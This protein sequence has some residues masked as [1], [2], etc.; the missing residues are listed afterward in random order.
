MQIKIE[1]CTLTSTAKRV[2][3]ENRFGNSAGLSK[4]QLSKSLLM[5]THKISLFAQWINISKF[6]AGILA[7]FFS[8]I[9]NNEVLTDNPDSSGSVIL[10]FIFGLFKLFFAFVSVSFTTLWVLYTFVGLSNFTN[11]VTEG[12][13]MGPNWLNPPFWL[14]TIFI[15]PTPFCV[16]FLEFIKDIV[17]SWLKPKIKG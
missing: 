12:F 2:R 3:I 7:T 8:I 13:V 14:I 5:N 17:W 15:I 4:L 11:R 1:Y 10:K 9:E 16:Y 6:F